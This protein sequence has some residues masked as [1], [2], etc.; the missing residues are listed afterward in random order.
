MNNFW[1]QT[2]ACLSLLC[3]R[4]G[5]LKSLKKELKTSS[6]QGLLGVTRKMRDLKGKKKNHSCCG[7]LQ[8]LISFLYGLLAYLPQGIWDLSSLTRAQ[9]HFF[10]IRRWIPK[11]LTTREVNFLCMHVGLKTG[12]S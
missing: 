11:S 7:S 2:V 12:L 3:I 10:C 9:T 6:K 8:W 5:N 1:I 4:K